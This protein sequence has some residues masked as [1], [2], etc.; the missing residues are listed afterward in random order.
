MATKP[1]PAGE[2]WISLADAVRL[3][4]EDRSTLWRKAEAQKIPSR[5]VKK[6][7]RDVYQVYR[8]A[9]EN[10]AGVSTIGE[11]ERLRDQ[12]LG[13]MR[14]GAFSGKP[15]SAKHI[16]IMEMYLGRY[17]EMLDQKP[18]LGGITSENLRKVLYSFPPVDYENRQ[19]WYYIKMHIYD[20]I[21]GFSKLL[22]RERIKQ[23]SDRFDMMECRPKQLFKTQRRALREDEIVA[24]LDFNRI[25]TT[26][27]T[28]YDRAM[29]DI[30]ICLY[31]YGGLRREEACHLRI[32][33][34]DLFDPECPGMYFMGKG[35]KE[36]WVPILP[37]LLARINTWLH[38]RAHSESPYLVV[39]RHGDPISENLVGKKFGNFK[40]ALKN[41]DF[42][43]HGLRY[44][45]ATIM[46]DRGVPMHYIQAWL[47][48]SSSKVTEL[49]I[50]A[51]KDDQKRWVR[52]NLTALFGGAPSQGP[53]VLQ[54]L[55]SA[56]IQA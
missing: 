10:N 6:G 18:T 2:D 52:K 7:S 40:R 22:V 54:A 9:L 34:M 24:A 29:M 53:T 51:T 30:L 32:E 26:G 16:E 25:R 31:S 20:A 38:I 56:S 33:D 47:G 4:G 44:S 39:D 13:E 42:L 23:K 41:K 50:K 28:K 37:E 19:D 15:L 45:F 5:T 49:Y 14:S 27:R 1:A 11:Y 35:R 48:H 12:W 36:R 43:P 8:P 21:T 46:A 3:T 55:K 17:W